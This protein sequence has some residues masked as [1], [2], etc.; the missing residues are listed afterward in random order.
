VRHKKSTLLAMVR[1]EA[2]LF[3]A[4][5]LLVL[6]PGQAWAGGGVFVG[7]GGSK[8]HGGFVKST[9]GFTTGSFHK[10][11][12]HKQ[13]FHK[14]AF[15]KPVPSVFPIPVDPWKSWG[16]RHVH[17]HH[18]FKH[19]FVAPGVVF[20]GG[21]LVYAATPVYPAPEQVVYAPA[22]ATYAAAPM[23]TVVEYATG[24][25]ELRGDGVTSAY[26]WVWIPRPPTGP[27]PE[28]APEPA[29][30]SAPPARD[31]SIGK[32]Y[33]WTDDEGVTTFTD[34]LENVPERYRSRAQPKA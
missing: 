20:G 3:V 19:S 6:V 16:K 11:A 9:A 12:F 32:I 24:R 28:V 2:R 34:R 33:R 14:P 4:A 8:G 22:P 29:P 13:A 21:T 31:R 17:H 1:Y 18:P 26:Q 15:H 23:P 25:Y 10:Q 7:G 30:Q 5:A 27:P